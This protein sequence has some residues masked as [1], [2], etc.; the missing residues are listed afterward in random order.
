MQQSLMCTVIL[1]LRNDEFQLLAPSLCLWLNCDEN[2]N[3]SDAI[4][5]FWN[6]KIT[7]VRMSNCYSNIM[8]F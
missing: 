8:N 7:R 5:E 1:K 6:K 4:L 3:A 2:C